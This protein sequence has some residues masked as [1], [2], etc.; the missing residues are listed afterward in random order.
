MHELV[1]LENFWAYPGPK[2]MDILRE[3]MTA[4]DASGAARLTQKITSALLTESYRQDQGAWEPE[5]EGELPV[6]EK[7][8]AYAT[9][10]ETY[11]PYFE[12][13]AVTPPRLPTGN[14]PVRN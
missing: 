7:M 12:V 6:A 9:T 13:L 5:E 11:R 2:L 14:G 3:R 1:P 4:G 8:D 10:A